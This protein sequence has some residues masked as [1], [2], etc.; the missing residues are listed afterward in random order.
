[1]LIHSSQYDNSLGERMLITQYPAKDHPDTKLIELKWSERKRLDRDGF[2][3][4]D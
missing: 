2:P 1:M 3:K 4:R